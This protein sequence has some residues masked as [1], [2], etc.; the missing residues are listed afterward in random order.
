[1]PTNIKK[2][3]LVLI[4]LGTS[5]IFFQNCS[6]PIHESLGSQDNQSSSLLG[7][8]TDPVVEQQAMGILAARCASC[9]SGAGA[10]GVGQI[11]DVAHLIATGLIVPGAPGLS[12]IILSEEAGRMPPGQPLSAAEQATLRQWVAG[13]PVNTANPGAII[14]P[15]SVPAPPTVVSGT[16]EQ[17][18]ITILQNACYSCHGTAAAGGLNQIT[19]AAYLKTAGQVVPGNALGSKLYQRM[20]GGTAAMPLPMMPPAGKLNAADLSLIADWINAGA[21]AP[22]PGTTSPPPTLPPLA[23]TYASIQANILGPKCIACH[24]PTLAKSGVRYDSYTL[25]LATVRKTLP[26]DS[27]LFTECKS[28]NMPPTGTPKLTSNELD[29][30]SAWITAG[31]ANN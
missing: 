13:N 18:A 28:G 7:A 6:A 24:G 17:K 15:V 8:G 21:A 29:V 12:P 26:L 19:D 1:M 5:S 20:L 27:K 22:A 11:M 10:G 25:T 16:L 4:L 9:H 23:A 30:L 14:P 3:I 31:A 2:T